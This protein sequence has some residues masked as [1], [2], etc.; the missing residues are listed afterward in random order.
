MFCNTSLDYWCVICVK[1]GFSARFSLYFLHYNYTEGV[2]LSCYPTCNSCSTWRHCCSYTARA[3]GTFGSEGFTWRLLSCAALGAATRQNSF[4]ET[5]II[6]SQAGPF[7]WKEAAYWLF[8]GAG[9]LDSQD[10]NC[11]CDQRAHARAL[12]QL[13]EPAAKTKQLRLVPWSLLAAAACPMYPLAKAGARYP[14]EK[15]S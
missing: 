13:L 8:A 10:W 4:W 6:P 7:T 14:P 3:A 12:N 1:F 9:A 15:C 5:A 11:S 2:H